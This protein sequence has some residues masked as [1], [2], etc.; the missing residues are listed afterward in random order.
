MGG[1]RTHRG[2]QPGWGDHDRGQRCRAEDPGGHLLP[3]AQ[4]GTPDGAHLHVEDSNGLER[5]SASLV[6]ERCDGE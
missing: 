5:G 6:L 2:P 4:D 3:L 1:R